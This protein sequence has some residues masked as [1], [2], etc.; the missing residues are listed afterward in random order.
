MR[1]AARAFLVSWV[2]AFAGTHEVVLPFNSFCSP[3]KAGVQRRQD[4]DIQPRA[5]L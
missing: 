4:T 1:S 5:A 2:P 3:A